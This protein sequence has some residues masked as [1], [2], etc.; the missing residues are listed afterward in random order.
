[1]SLGLKILAGEPTIT[2]NL[3][4]LM[5]MRAMQI[6]ICC[7]ISMF[8]A[9]FIKVII[10]SIKKRRFEYKMFFTTGGLPSSHSS[11]CVSLCVLLGMLQYH[12]E[13]RLSWAFAVA[14]VVSMVVMYDA[15]GVRLEASKHAK[16]LNR[17]AD[18]IPVDE[19]EDLYGR[20]GKLKEMLGH[21]GVEVLAGAAL[22]VAVGFAGFGI[23]MMIG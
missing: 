12:D 16:I 19:K 14:V 15:M 18:E 9:Q 7:L 20:K 5:T 4:A 10:Y 2:Q 3:E 23:I 6:I 22:G 13:N 17:L 21:R 1:M 8:L 11:L